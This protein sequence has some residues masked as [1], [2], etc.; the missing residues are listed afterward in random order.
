MTPVNDVIVARACGRQQVVLA[1]AAELAVQ[2]KDTAAQQYRR[3][4][5]IWLYLTFTICLFSARINTPKTHCLAS[6]DLLHTNLA[7]A[8]TRFD[9]HD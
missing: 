1:E 6:L 3:L 5:R 9:Y 8:G 2:Y 4:R 7:L